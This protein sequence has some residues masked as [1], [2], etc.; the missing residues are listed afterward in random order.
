MYIILSENMKSEGYLKNVGVDRGTIS[1][2]FLN[3]WWW[4]IDSAGSEL[5]TAE[6]SCEL[7]NDSLDFVKVGNCMTSWVTTS[8]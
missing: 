6:S 7:D 1:E 2:S 5:K 8:F 3:V 4:K